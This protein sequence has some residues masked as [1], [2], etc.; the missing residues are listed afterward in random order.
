MLFLKENGVNIVKTVLES[1]IYNLQNT[2]QEYFS[3]FKLINWWRFSQSW[4]PRNNKILFC[5]AWKNNSEW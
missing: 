5:F 4:K 2:C 3:G 1:K